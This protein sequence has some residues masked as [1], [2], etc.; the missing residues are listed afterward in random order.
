MSDTHY[1]TL[2]KEQASLWHETCLKLGIKSTLFH[3]T[4]VL[5]V[6]DFAEREVAWELFKEELKRIL[7][8]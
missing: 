4:K 6:C 8:I 5:T 2:P 3:E 1:I 7:E